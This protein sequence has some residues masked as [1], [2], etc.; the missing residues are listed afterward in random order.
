MAVQACRACEG[1]QIIFVAVYTPFLS[2][3]PQTPFLPQDVKYPCTSVCTC[4]LACLHAYLS[5]SARVLPFVSAPVC[6]CVQMCNYEPRCVSL[7][8][9]L[10]LYLPTRTPVSVPDDED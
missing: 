1:G 3:F 7:G 6:F 2:A 9:L 4:A 10:C 5:T 8:L